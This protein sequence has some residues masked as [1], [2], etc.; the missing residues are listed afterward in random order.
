MNNRIANNRCFGDNQSGRHL[1]SNLKNARVAIL[2]AGSSDWVIIAGPTGYQQDEAYFL[3]HI[4]NTIYQALMTY[5]G[6][7]RS[8]LEDWVVQRHKQIEGGVLIYIAHQLDFFG[9]VMD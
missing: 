1:I 8:K 4:V 3:H 5:P 9:T 7:D 6:L 2:A